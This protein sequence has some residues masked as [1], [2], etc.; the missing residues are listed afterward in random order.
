MKKTLSLILAMLMLL[1]AFT[2]CS[3]NSADNAG[4]TTAPAVS[5][6]NV[7]AEAGDIAAG[8]VIGGMPEA[9]ILQFP[10]AAD[11]QI[12]VIADALRGVLAESDTVLF[13]ASRAMALER[14][15]NALT[16]E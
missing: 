12:P 10:D 8:A 2:S 11:A 4:E 7:G 13:N 14:L 16:A 1:S 3:D 6:E 5:A 15:V 9:H